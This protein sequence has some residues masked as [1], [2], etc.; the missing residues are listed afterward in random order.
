MAVG[1]VKPQSGVQADRNP[2]SISNPCQ[3]SHL[4]LPPRVGVKGFLKC[5][6]GGP[7]WVHRRSAIIYTYTPFFSTD[8]TCLGFKALGEN[9]L[10]PADLRSSLQ[11]TENPSLEMMSC[12]AA[13]QRLWSLQTN[14]GARTFRN[15]EFSMCLVEKENTQLQY[16]FQRSNCLGSL[17]WTSDSALF[18]PLI[19]IIPSTVK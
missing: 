3:L 17:M 5:Q 12:V 10:M 13:L 7:V 19:R 1:M 15:Q 11:Y 4:T 18:L 8:I 14:S 2:Y 16:K 6:I 9:V